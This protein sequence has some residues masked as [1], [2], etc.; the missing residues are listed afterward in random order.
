[1]L[2]VVHFVDTEFGILQDVLNQ[3]FEVA[4]ALMRFSLQKTLVS[5]EGPEMP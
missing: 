3:I 1:M 4:H 5:G 2:V